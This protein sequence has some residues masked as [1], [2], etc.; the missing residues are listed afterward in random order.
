[1]M[2][3]NQVKPEKLYEKAALKY[4][5]KAMANGKELRSELLYDGGNKSP[6]NTLK[7]SCGA[8]E[9]K[10][11]NDF[12]SAVKDHGIGDTPFFV[13]SKK[14]SEEFIDGLFVGKDFEEV[15]GFQVTLNATHTDHTASYWA[16]HVDQVQQKA[17]D[18]TTKARVVWVVPE[19]RYDGFRAAKMKN[20]ATVNLKAKEH[21]RLDR[22]LLSAIDE[23]KK[24]KHSKQ[25]TEELKTA[26]DA[27]AKV[28][29][30]RQDILSQ[31][32]EWK[33]M[34]P[35]SVLFDGE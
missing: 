18:G 4:V 20:T 14:H 15:R 7:L 23:A 11:C 10:P 34:V 9:L 8:L 1:M 26:K 22:D 32:E 13:E 19:S 2:S 21:T 12:A 25:R 3:M 31:C 16:E 27:L 35:V 33:V 5:A 30:H 6:S 17:K 24:L 28:L 29:D